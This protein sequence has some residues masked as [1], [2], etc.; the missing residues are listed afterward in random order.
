MCCVVPLPTKETTPGTFTDCL[1]PE[2]RFRAP[3]VQSTTAPTSW[4]QRGVWYTHVAHHTTVEHKPE[5]C[6]SGEKKNLS[7]SIRV[8]DRLASKYP[9]LPRYSANA[10]SFHESWSSL[11]AWKLITRRPSK[12]NKH[13]WSWNVSSLSML[14]LLRWFL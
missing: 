7:A 8:V 10:C 2:H 1:R 12:I 13:P 14:T 9:K 6:C 4:H 5:I 3:V 11:T